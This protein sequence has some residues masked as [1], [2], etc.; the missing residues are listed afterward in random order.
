MPWT[1]WMATCWT[2]VPYESKSPDTLV[3]TGIRDEAEAEE[4]EEDIAIVI[5]LGLVPDPGTEEEDPD[6]DPGPGIAGV[7]DPPEIDPAPQEADREAPRIGPRAPRMDPRAPRMDRK[8]PRKNQKA[9]PRMG[10]KA[11]G[12]DPRAQKRN[13]GVGRRVRREGKVAPEVEPV[14][15]LDPTPKEADEKLSSSSSHAPSLLLTG[16]GVSFTNS[17]V[18]SL[19]VLARMRSVMSIV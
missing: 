8:A 7:E 5:G 11:Q 1:S 12:K 2:V 6:L 4:T 14:Q 16:A 18:L 19:N 3:R 9:R 17:F 10:P 13:R 15:D